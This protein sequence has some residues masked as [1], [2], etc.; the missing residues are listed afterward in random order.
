MVLSVVVVMTAIAQE[1][2]EVEVPVLPATVTEFV[3]LRNG[4]AVTPEGGAAMFVVAMETY[5]ADSE[6]GLDFFTAILVNNSTLLRDDPNGYGGKA[7][8]NSASY[9]IRRLDDTPWIATSYWL[10][11]S[12]GNE[13][14]I[15]VGSPRIARVSRNPYSVISETEVKV[16]VFCTGAD[17]P[18]PVRLQRNNR[19]VWK[20]VEFSSLVLGVRTPEVSEDDEL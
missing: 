12:P 7:P 14:R 10:G 20:V 15:P 8:G 18:R 19:G 9:L 4:I 13:Y 17:S 16:Y 5:A 11:T 1:S 6:L 2:I 3:D